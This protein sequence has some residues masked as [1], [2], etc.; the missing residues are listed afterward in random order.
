M[1]K[2][3]YILNLSF[4]A[5]FVSCSGFLK[6]SSQ[7][8]VRPGTLDDLKQLMLQE[9]YSLSDYFIPHIDLMTDDIESM[10][11]KQNDQKSILETYSPL[12][13]WERDMDETIQGKIDYWQKYYKKI[14]GCNV[15]LSMVDKMIGTENERENIKGQALALRAYYYFMLI[16]IYGYPYNQ[17]SGDLNRYL[18]VPLILSPKVLDQ[19]PKRN[20]LKEVYDQIENDLL[21]A[22]PMLERNGRNNGVY[23]VTDLFAHTMLSR[24]YLYQNKWEKSIEHSNYV[25]KTKKSLVKLSDHFTASESWEVITY[26][27][28]FTK[29]VYDVNSIENIWSFSHGS[30]F[31][32]FGTPGYDY[33]PAFCISSDLVNLYEFNTKNVNDYKDLRMKF[34]VVHYGIDVSTQTTRPHYGSKNNRSNERNSTK[35][36]RVPELYLNRA[37][38]IIRLALEGRRD[39]VALDQAMKDLN[40]IR[41]KRYDTRKVAYVAVERPANLDE[42]L[43][44]CLDERRRELCMEEHRWFDLRRYGMPE[45]I[46]NISMS[47]G[48]TENYTLPAKSNLYVM[49]IP[50]DAMIKNYNLVQ[51]PD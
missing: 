22:T 13:K 49:R 38:A 1:K 50:K 6:E 2:I 32:F 23:R 17:A 19:Y 44:F 15:T 21:L 3:K 18:G 9:A 37:E 26:S 8:L 16:N 41:E 36:M 28:D 29:N 48:N 43:Q 27:C 24:L 30:E 14:M 5:L 45:I 4:L 51:N 39:E 7:D 25:L 12:F 42:M 31:G 33:P 40:Y 47:Q 11:P 35:G 46:H 34:Y 20:T 10:Y